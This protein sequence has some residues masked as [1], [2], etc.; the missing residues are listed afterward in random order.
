MNTGMTKCHERALMGIYR[1]NYVTQSVNPHCNFSGLLWDYFRSFSKE[2]PQFQYNTKNSRTLSIVVKTG[3][4]LFPVMTCLVLCHQLIYFST[5]IGLSLNIRDPPTCG[6][7]IVYYSH[8]HA[9]L[10]KLSLLFPFPFPLQ[11]PP[12]SKP[13][14]FSPFRLCTYVCVCVVS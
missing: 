1:L 8:V 10:V 14:F 7:H 5:N 3:P 11:R 4:A 6:S 13:G 9:P 12:I 2:Y